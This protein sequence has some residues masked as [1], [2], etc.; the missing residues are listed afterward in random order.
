MK[1]ILVTGASS[2]LGLY[3][4]KYANKNG[5]DLVTVGKDKNKVLKLKSQ[6]NDENKK[7]CHT[8]DLNNK[9]NFKSLLSCLKKEKF[10]VIIHCMGGGFGKHNSLISQKDLNELFNIN[11]SLAVEINKEIIEKKCFKK[12]LKIIHI[13]SIA[14]IESTASVGYSMVKASLIAYVKTLSKRLIKNNIYVHCILPGAFEYENNAFERLKKKN[15]KIYNQFIKHR[16][17]GG[18]IANGESFLGLFDFLISSNGDPLTGSSTVADFS[19]TNSFR[20]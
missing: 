11:V 1:N 15:K 4:S 6:L 16:L 19:E 3:L 18:K 13:S 7:K 17:P 14:G 20:I 10:D 12:N 5:Y 8:L 2:G 9:K